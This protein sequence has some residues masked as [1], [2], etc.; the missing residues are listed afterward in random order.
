MGLIAAS[1]GNS[2]C[3]VNLLPA[4]RKAMTG[5]GAILPL[6]LVFAKDCFP[7]PE[8]TSEARHRQPFRGWDSDAH[9]G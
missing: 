5:N 2:P 8:P 3:K 4:T 1:L 6:G 7:T 9:A